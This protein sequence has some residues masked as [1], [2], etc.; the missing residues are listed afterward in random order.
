MKH[1]EPETTRP[2]RWGPFFPE[3]RKKA[4]PKVF[5]SLNRHCQAHGNDPSFPC[6]DPPSGRRTPRSDEHEARRA[7]DT[8]PKAP[9][10]TME[11]KGRIRG[12]RDLSVCAFPRSSTD[13]KWESPVAPSANCIKALRRPISPPPRL[14]SVCRATTE[15]IEM[16]GAT[17][18]LPASP[19]RR[20]LMKPNWTRTK[21]IRDSIMLL[22]A[23]SILHISKTRDPSPSPSPHIPKPPFSFP[24]PSSLPYYPTETTSNSERILPPTKGNKGE[25]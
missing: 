15:Q 13:Q 21:C 19:A 16:N 8:R 9:R 23:L 3:P 18:Q 7:T 5:P 20:K 2:S 11:H 12:A 10:Y 17:T 4:E 1:R 6:I 25:K 14:S 24:F 22:H